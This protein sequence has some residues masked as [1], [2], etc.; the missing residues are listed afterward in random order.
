MCCVDVN[1]YQLDKTNSIHVNVE[2]AG[3]IRDE[4]INGSGIPSAEP[5]AAILYLTIIPQPQVANMQDP[6]LMQRP[7]ANVRG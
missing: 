4:N 5:A 2:L 1:A 7:T 6:H 3:E